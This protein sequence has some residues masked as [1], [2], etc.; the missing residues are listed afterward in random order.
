MLL[1]YFLLSLAAKVHGTSINL[2]HCLLINILVPPHDPL[3]SS[4]SIHITVSHI[5]KFLYTTV[6]LTQK[7]KPLKIFWLPNTTIDN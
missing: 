2:N 6:F 1:S 4:Y 5:T 7:Q 3:C